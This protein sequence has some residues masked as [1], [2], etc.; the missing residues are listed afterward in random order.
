MPSNANRTEHILSKLIDLSDETPTP[1]FDTLI[2]Q[3]P[4]WDTDNKDSDNTAK[5]MQRFFEHMHTLF[6][7]SRHVVKPTGWMWLVAQDAYRPILTTGSEL[8]IDAIDKDKSIHPLLLLTNISVAEAATRFV[9]DSLNLP[10]P[11]GNGAI[12]WEDEKRRVIVKW[13]ASHSSGLGVA[14]L[15]EPTSLYVL[16][17]GED[18]DDF[19][20]QGWIEGID[21]VKNTI[22]TQGTSVDNSAYYVP[23]SSLNSFGD[24]LYWSKSMVK[25]FELMGL[26]WRLGA[27]AQQ[28]R[29]YLKGEF[30]LNYAPWNIGIATRDHESALLFSRN[31]VGFWINEE[32]QISTSWLGLN[33]LEALPLFITKTTP[34]NGKVLSLFTD[35]DQ[36]EDAIKFSGTKA[37]F[38]NI[39]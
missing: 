30:F 29:W 38:L 31:A 23:S 5:Q 9:A 37:N 34:N 22:Q 7:I 3:A 12:W 6:A 1:I 17:T 13:V 8:D 28:G 36:I 18:A 11:T 32:P 27:L 15:V 2:V 24:L 19:V 39:G 14:G 20:I 4:I 16:V 25:P 33:Y 35:A 26:P 10:L 21:L